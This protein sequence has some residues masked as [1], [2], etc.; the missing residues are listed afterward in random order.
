MSNAAFAT[1]YFSET[2]TRQIGETEDKRAVWQSNYG[3]PFFCVYD[4]RDVQH[5]IPITE[6]WT[7]YPFP[8]K[9]YGEIINK[10]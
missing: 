10:L 6:K 5:L 4:A 1:P 3:P 8:H 9:T 7:K 2:E